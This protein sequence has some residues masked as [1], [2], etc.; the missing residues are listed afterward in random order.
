MIY[1]RIKISDTTNIASINSLIDI[2]E[3]A[4]GVTIDWSTNKLDIKLTINDLETLDII[5]GLLKG[6]F[7]DGGILQMD[8][9]RDSDIPGL[10]LNYR[11]TISPSSDSPEKQ[12]LLKLFPA[13]LLIN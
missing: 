2:L 1:A 7:S 11:F 4:R 5:E 10:E 13:K 3:G 6:L 12:Y 9:S 8:V